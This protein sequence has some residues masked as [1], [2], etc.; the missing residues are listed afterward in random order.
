MYDLLEGI[1]YHAI[2]AYVFLSTMYDVIRWLLTA[3]PWYPS[4]NFGYA[5]LSLA[6]PR[7]DVVAR[8]AKPSCVLWSQ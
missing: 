4:Y 2:I 7:C 6:P 8:T 3:F 5:D 1:L